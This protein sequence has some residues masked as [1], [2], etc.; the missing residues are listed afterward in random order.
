SYNISDNSRL[1]SIDLS[2][3]ETILFK[4][5]SICLRLS[6]DFLTVF[7]ASI[8]DFEWFIRIC[9]VLSSF[10]LE[11]LYNFN[12]VST[13]VQQLFFRAMAVI[14]LFTRCMIKNDC[15]SR[16]L[17]LNSIERCLSFLLFVIFIIRLTRRII[18]V[19]LFQMATKGVSVF[20]V[21]SNE[22][23]VKN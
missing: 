3:C 22:K 2:A 6:K 23:V 13:S 10:S 15:Y 18:I 16:D 20:K 19:Y 8:L 5:S 21:P 7:M 14:S 9:R 1:E 4:S 12:R 17:A 11:A